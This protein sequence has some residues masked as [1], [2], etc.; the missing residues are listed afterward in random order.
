MC[1]LLENSARVSHQHRYYEPLKTKV[2]LGY[3]PHV[4][5]HEQRNHVIRII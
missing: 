2:L 4:I 3:S 1:L 5:R